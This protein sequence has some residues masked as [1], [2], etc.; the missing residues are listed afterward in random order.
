MSD[1]QVPAVAVPGGAR[2]GAA[3]AEP[4]V[5]S[6]ASRIAGTRARIALGAIVLGSFAA[7]FA[8]ALAHPSPQYFQDEYV[9]AALARSIAHGRLTVR[10]G[11]AGFPALLEP[12]LAAAGWWSNDPAVAYRVTQGLHALAMSLAAVPVYLLARR[13]NVTA[14][15]ALLAALATVALPPSAG[16]RTSPPMPWA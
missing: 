16:A 14:R 10:G 15:D 11:P 13:L 1:L 7:R 6:V 8:A 2:A 4:V 3:P 5:S 9:Y 12:V